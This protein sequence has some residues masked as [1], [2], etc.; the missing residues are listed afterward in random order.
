MMLAQL[1][2]ATILGVVKDPSGAVVPGAKITAR[3]TDTGQCRTV[4]TG[5]DGSY[6]LDA[7]AV[8]NYPITAEATGFQTEVQSGLTLTV[9][10]E[11]V[12]N[13]ALQVGQ[14][15]QT[16]SVTGQAEIVSTTTSSLSSGGN[17]A[18]HCRPA[19]QR[20]QLQ[21]FDPASAG[22]HTI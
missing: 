21:Q 1:T 4:V 22:S 9:G 12:I 8:G 15:T 16:V 2:T 19:A 13:F 11:A 7:L 18:N 14:A 10:Q 20:P 3:D 17:P 6:R 5:T